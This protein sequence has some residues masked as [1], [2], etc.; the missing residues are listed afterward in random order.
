MGKHRVVPGPAITLNEAKALSKGTTLYS[1]LYANA[2][3]SPARYKVS[4]AP[5][6]WKRQPNR[7]EI[8]VKWGIYGYGY[9]DEHD[10]ENLSLTLEVIEYPQE[11][12]T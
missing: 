11:N 2:D 6:T 7:V 8:P 5:K 3:D 4:G 1:R 10:L 12:K 9:V